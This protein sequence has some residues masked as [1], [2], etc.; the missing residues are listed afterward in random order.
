MGSG[1]GYRPQTPVAWYLVLLLICV[2]G[3]G[4]V[5]YSRYERTHPAAS[6]VASHSSAL[7]STSSLWKVGLEADVCGKIQR[8]PASSSQAQA[9]TTDGKGVVTIEPSRSSTP[10]AFTGSHAVLSAFLVPEGVSLTSTSLQLPPSHAPVPSPTT[11]S[12]TTASSSTTSTV[13]KA[14]KLYHNG[15]SCNGKPATVRV[16]VWSSPSAKSP[17]ML[18]GSFGT[19]RFKNG[20]LIMLAFLPKSATIPKPTSAKVVADFLVSNPAGVN[21]ST[22]SSTPTTAAPAT[23]APASSTTAPGSSSSTSSTAKGSSSTGG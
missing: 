15:Q 11:P 22:A 21:P 19:L 2:A 23:T 16:A 13:P 12:S 17:R 8:L 5:A 3:I 4:L 18:T 6:P 10:S 14:G 7:P 20:Q 1:R 9:Y